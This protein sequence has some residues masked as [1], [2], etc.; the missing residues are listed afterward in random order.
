MHIG[1]SKS[2]G[3]KPNDPK[4][5]PLDPDLTKVNREG[6]EQTS[7][8]AQ[9]RLREAR[10]EEAARHRLSLPGLALARQLY[11]AVRA[12]GHELLGTQALMLALERLNAAEPDPPSH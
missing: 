7:A 2:Y 9:E 5:A 11:E 12:Q 4:K 8:A 3:P 6:I 1:N 10:L